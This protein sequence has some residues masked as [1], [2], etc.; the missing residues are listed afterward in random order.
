MSP[1]VRRFWIINAVGPVNLAA[2]VGLHR[3]GLID[4]SPWMWAVAAGY[5]SAVLVITF[6]YWKTLPKDEQ[7][8]GLP[9]LTVA[10]YGAI[11]TLVQAVAIAGLALL[12]LALWQGPNPLSVILGR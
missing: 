10:R 9:Y 1:K 3:F 12:V 6:L 5:I 11:A 8:G 4:R 2:W 7:S